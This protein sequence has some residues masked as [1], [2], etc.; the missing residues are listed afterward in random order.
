MYRLCCTK[1]L[2]GRM[3][4]KPCEATPPTTT[5][6]GD[7]YATVLF[8]RPQVAL[9]VNERTLLP[10]LLPLAPAATLP[11]RLPMELARQLAACGLAE[12]FVDEE[13]ASMQECCVT[14]TGNRTLIGM[15]NE[16]SFLADAYRDRGESVDL[17]L[18]ARRLATTPC[19]P[20]KHQSPARVLAALR[21][22][23]AS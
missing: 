20:L 19:G 5:V 2:L 17:S 10:I 1:K 8:W 7:W 18:L 22:P 16:F 12:R 9:L 23:A 4:L 11:S 3:N 13:L 15:L 21:L 14:K 6:L